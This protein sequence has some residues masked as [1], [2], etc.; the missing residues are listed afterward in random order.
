MLRL[1]KLSTAYGAVDALRE[2]D[3]SIE[4]GEIVA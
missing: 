1:E 3:L 4:T 2:I